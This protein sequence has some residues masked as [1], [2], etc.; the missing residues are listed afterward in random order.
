LRETKAKEVPAKELDEYL[1][2]GYGIFA[3]TDLQWATLKFSPTAARWVSTQTWHPKQRSH[4]D[5][6]GSLLLEVPYSNDRELV[7]EILKFGPDVEV[8]APNVLR[9]RVAAALG[10]AAAR[11]R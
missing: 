1:G 5:D 8:L 6:D 11:Y 10:A 3:G 2:S 4:T 9:K 7:M